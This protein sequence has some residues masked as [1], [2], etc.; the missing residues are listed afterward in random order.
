MNERNTLSYSWKRFEVEIKALAEKIGR[1]KYKY[2]LVVSKGGL[3]PAYYLAKE[4][5][6]T[7]IKTI[8]ISS[9]TER[10]QTSLIEHT[11]IG[12][13]ELAL[14]NQRD[15]LIVDDLS[16]SGRTFGYLKKKFPQIKQA[17]LVIK[18]HTPKPD[19]YVTMMDNIW[20]RWSWE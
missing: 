2:I 16:D 3:I 15:W 6:I 10:K 18:K 1:G 19:Y 5:G 13:K 14:E 8:C 7:I 17:C 9:Y 11:Y 4:L 12:E 20:L